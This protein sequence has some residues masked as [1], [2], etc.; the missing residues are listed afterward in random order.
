MQ[1]VA[2]LGKPHLDIRRQA[3]PHRPRATLLSTG[4]S[5]RYGGVRFAVAFVLAAVVVVPVA[6]ARPARRASASGLRILYASDWAGPTE[7]FAAD[8]TGRAPL[9]QVTF[10]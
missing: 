4:P 5:S 2:D 8:P 6:G 9:R 10:G 7:I 1:R 3:N